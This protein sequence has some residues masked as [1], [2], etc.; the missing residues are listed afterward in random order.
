[1]RQERHTCITRISNG[2]RMPEP[3]FARFIAGAVALRQPLLQA[4]GKTEVT[5]ARADLTVS[6]PVF[7]ELSH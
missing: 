5:A 3:L 2:N 6:P 7:M 4:I 1:M